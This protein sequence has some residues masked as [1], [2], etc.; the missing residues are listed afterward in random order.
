[1]RGTR[2][3]STH[4][5]RWGFVLLLAGVCL[6]STLA[7]AHPGSGIVIDRFGQ[8]YFVDMVSGVWK[9]DTHGALTHLPGPAFHWMALDADNRFGAVRLPSGS[10][11]DVARL[12][13]NPVL[14]LASSFPVVIGRDGILYYPTHG[15]GVPNP[16]QM[17]KLLPSGQTASMASLPSTTVGLPIR[18]LNGLAAGPE[19]SVYYTEKDAIRRISR[20]GHVSIVVENILRVHCASIPEGGPDPLLRGLDVDSAGTIYVAATGCGSVF[21]ITPAGQVTLLF[22]L[23]SPWSPTGIA[24]FGKDVYVLEFLHPESD[25]RSEMLPRVRKITPD[26]RTTIVATVTHH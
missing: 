13:A 7:A 3:S 18:D 9:V 17:M 12:R 25:D 4:Q 20:D 21:K 14:L 10:G 1:M 6:F 8:I 16:L 5:T 15:T 19:G 23:P 26:G 11:G 2:T 24:L 22:Q